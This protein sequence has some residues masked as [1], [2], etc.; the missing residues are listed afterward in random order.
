VNH[1]P[2]STPEDRPL[3][4]Q[5]HTLIRWLLDHGAAHAT[6]FVPQLLDARVVARCPCGCASIDFSIAGQRAPAGASMDILSDYGWRDDHGH[7]FGAF[8]F[9]RGGLLAGLELWS[10]DSD[11]T[12]T[13]LPEPQELT[14][15]E[16]TRNVNIPP[17]SPE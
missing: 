10:I 12:A 4:T 6:A 3:T 13:R 7:L 9:A 1:P 8:V 15:L 14:P 11:A 16:I 17:N 5:E 2:Q